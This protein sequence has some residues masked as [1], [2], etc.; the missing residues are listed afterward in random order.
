MKPYKFL[1]FVLG[2]AAVVVVACNKEPAHQSYLN[3]TNDNNKQV[4]NNLATTSICDQ[5]AYPDTIFYLKPLSS[6]D[7]I[8][9][10]AKPLT[11]TFGVFPA[12]L[13][14]NPLNGNINVTKSET[15]LDYRVWFIPQGTTDTCIKYITISGV[16]YT[17]SIYVLA[18]S[19]GIAQPI[20][21]AMPLL[22]VD[23]SSGCEFDDGPDDDN[24]NGLADEPPAGQQL[25]PQGFVI[26]KK[27]GAINFKKSLQNGVLGTNP[28]P[29]TYKDFVLNY[30][31]G[32][33]SAKALNKIAFR[34]Y[35]Y[36][37]QSQIPAKLKD[38]IATKQSQVLL[39]GKEDESADDSGGH[40]SNSGSSSFSAASAA[41]TTARKGTG[42]VKCRPPYI[43]V[44]Q[45]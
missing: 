2:A 28:A 16:N 14:I 33:K 38:D 29:G 17:D 30:R 3:S 25:V 12:G 31:I 15:G 43:I 27:T 4:S 6:T 40:G 20:Y 42:E 45:Q 1:L 19:T 34:L 13:K 22:A 26:N 32:D 37:S 9:K 41:F 18:S 23:C 11:G 24:G 36:Q 10:P 7:Y 39:E 5:F 21:N 44:T 35:Y 8:V